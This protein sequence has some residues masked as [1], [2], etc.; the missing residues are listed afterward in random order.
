VWLHPVCPAGIIH[1]VERPEDEH[2]KLLVSDLAERYM[3]RPGVVIVCTITCT[4]DIDTQVRSPATC[5]AS[6]AAS[7]G[8]VRRCALQPSS[9]F[10]CTQPLTQKPLIA[11]VHGSDM[12]DVGCASAGSQMSDD[13]TLCWL[14]VSFAGLC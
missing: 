14:P 7:S 2:Y 13:I 5:A 1:N 11:C 9:D 10:G 4:A 3:R 6:A 12:L 8:H